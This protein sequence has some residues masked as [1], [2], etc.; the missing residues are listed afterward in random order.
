MDLPLCFCRFDPNL[1]KLLSDTSKVSDFGPLVSTCQHG[2]EG[3]HDDVDKFV[4]D[5]QQDTRICQ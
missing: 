2:A 5:F 1:L 3:Y 4:L